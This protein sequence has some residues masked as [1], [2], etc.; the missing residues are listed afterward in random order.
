MEKYRISSKTLAVLPISKTRTKVYERE[1]III[2][3]QNV[4]KIIEE[5]CYYYGSSYDLRKKY[6]EK[7]I[8]VT[9][10]SPIV[11]EDSSNI[12]FF[13]TCSPRLK[14]CGWISLNNLAEN[15]RIGDCSQIKFLNNVSINLDVSNN[16][17][18]HQILRSARLESISRKRQLELTKILSKTI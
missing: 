15:K 2:V 8:G 7:L 3:D 10:K 11:I 14:T 13:P 4:Q 18:D 9:H 5:N 1:D 12:I 6:T 16:V 17:I